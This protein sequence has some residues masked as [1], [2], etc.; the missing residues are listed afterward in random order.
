VQYKT[1]SP[2][3]FPISKK[4]E[5]QWQQVAKTRNGAMCPTHRKLHA[6][7]TQNTQAPHRGRTQEDGDGD[8]DTTGQ[9]WQ[10]SKAADLHG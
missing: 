8:G 1:A 6:T 10:H 2:L 5:R 4:E 9:Q 3:N 7:E